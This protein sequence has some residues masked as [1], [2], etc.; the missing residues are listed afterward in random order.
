MESN[1]AGGT[2]PERKGVAVRRLLRS[3]FV[4][5]LVATLRLLLCLRSLPAR[6]H[7]STLGVGYGHGWGTSE[8]E[9]QR[10]SG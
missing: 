4:R 3:E 2:S 6:C 7:A 9:L 8:D 1:F 5:T 10:V